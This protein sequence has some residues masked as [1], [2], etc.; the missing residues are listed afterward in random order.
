M[1]T[2]KGKKLD[3]VLWDVYVGPLLVFHSL[4]VGNMYSEISQIQVKQDIAN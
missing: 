2:L 4:P 3:R 1:K